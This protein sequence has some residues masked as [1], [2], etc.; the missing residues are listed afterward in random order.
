MAGTTPK[1]NLTRLLNERSREAAVQEN[2]E[3]KTAEI[4]TPEDGVSSTADIYD[5]IPSKGNFY[6]VEDVQDLKQSI[7]LLGVLQPLLVTDEEEDG[8][9]RII[10]GHRRRLAVMQLVDEGKE[11]FRRVPILIKPKKNAILDRLALIM[12][13]RFREKTDWERMTEALETEKLVLE[14]KESMSIPGRTRDLL[15]EI[16]ETSPAQIGR[17]KAIYNNLIPELMAEFKANRIVVSVIYE[18]SG[19]PADYQQQAAEMFR[20]NEVLT[21]ADI[22]QLKKNYE[23]AQQ[24]PGQMDMNQFEDQKPEEETETGAEGT[25]GA[26]EAA[27]QQPEYVDP[28]PEQIT[29]LCYSCTHYEDCHDKTA[30]VTSCNAYKNRREAQKT[31]E[32]RYNEEQAAIDRETRKKLREKQQEEKMQQLPS[33]GQQK[34]RDIRLT[35]QKYAEITAGKLTFLLLKKDGFKIGEELELGEFTDGKATG[36]KIDV[37]IVYIWADW[38]GLDDDYCII[39]FNVTA[40]DE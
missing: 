19:L 14:L 29:S 23:A 34:Q 32:E 2:K 37:E 15:A 40:F 6:S 10:A 1:F 12:A 30:T 39:G 27:G 21:I 4:A 28:Q 22:K 33:D 16:I 35:P 7:E 36:R 5:L 9:R 11:R 38:T 24:I 3:E 26:E 18:A 17:Y 13:N 8:K 31:D 25:E 20:E